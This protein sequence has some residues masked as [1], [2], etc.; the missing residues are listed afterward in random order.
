M[1]IYS[2]LF[3][4]RSC[5]DVDLRQQAAK[6]RDGEYDAICSFFKDNNFTEFN[7]F[8]HSTEGSAILSKKEEDIP[9]FGQ[10]EPN[11][12]GVSLKYLGTQ[13]FYDR[14]LNNLPKMREY[15]FK[16]L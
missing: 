1:T 5:S 3:L 16:E 14:M 9:P 6:R 4:I 11:R 15:E 12:F 8:F 13:S 7:G 10:F 2:H